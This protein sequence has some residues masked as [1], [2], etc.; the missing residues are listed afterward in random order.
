MTN[1]LIPA[2]VFAAVLALGGAWVVV[3]YAKRKIVEER[4]AGSPG[5]VLSSRPED[6]SKRLSGV[7]DKMG[8]VLGSAN[9]SQ[10]LREQLARAG[11][12][13]PDAGA[14]YLG[15]KTALLLAGATVLPVVLL[16]TKLGL[17]KAVFAAFLAAGTLYF[18]PNMVVGLRIRGRSQKVREHLP[19]ALD[20]LE[21]CVSAGMGLDT[22]WNAVADEIRD[23]C[24]IL[25]DEMALTNLEI[26]LGAPRAEAMR[27]MA[28]R[29]GGQDISSLVAILVQSE[30]FGTSIA[31]ALQTFAASMRQTRSQRAEERAEKMAVKLLIPMV[32]FIFPAVMIV[33]VGP[34][35]ITLR[36]VLGKF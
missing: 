12:H 13:N 17:S 28:F 2:L 24:P 9:A 34:A 19:E 16:A 10:Q 25:A 20:L 7:M 36:N 5:G 4:L 3:L 22:A 21:I 8:S 27:H 31:T 11:F 26:H 1:L 6:S 15:A 35:G 18:I 30:R 33:L 32:L 29:T 14:K 23:V